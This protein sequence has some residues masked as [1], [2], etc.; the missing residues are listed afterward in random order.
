MSP[1]DTPADFTYTQVSAGG[2][3]A[4]AVGS[5]GNA[6]AWGY[7]DTGQIGDGTTTRRTTPVKVMSPADTPAD[8]TYTQVSGGNNYS[9]AVGS[10]GNAYAWGSNQ[11]G[12]LGINIAI[13]WGDTNPVPMRVRDPS[14]PKDKSK[15]LQA[16]QVSAGYQHSLAVG[17]DG[18]A[19]AW[20]DNENGQLGNDSIPTGQ[21]NSK[22]QSPAP[23]PVSFN[24]QLVITGVRFDQTPASGLTRGDGSSV[25]VTTSAHA[26]GTVTVNVDY[27]LGGAPKTPD[28][29]LQYTYLPAG[30]LPNAG[31]EG[32]LLALAT[33][34]TGMGG[35]LAS[36][37][38]RRETHSL[39][40]ASHG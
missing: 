31:G 17:S 27:T 5:D 40:L 33:G 28:T 24:L 18:N 14:S 1:A 13:W 32:I 10:D 26:P 37:R 38:H 2:Y 21:Y 8:F 9:L 20:G 23:V 29:S 7:N 39:S 11:K 35:V 36:R 22:A 19:Y 12:V 3:H 4:L 30:V 34:M 25:T 16:E 6:Y 15:G